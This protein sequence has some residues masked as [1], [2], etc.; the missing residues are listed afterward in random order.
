MCKLFPIFKA[1]PP[2]TIVLTSSDG[3]CFKKESNL[4]SIIC[5]ARRL[6]CYANR[7]VENSN[8]FR[9]IAQNTTEKDISTTG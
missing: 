6:G 2:L 1:V 4:N 5:R 9:K 3:V 7:A 8:L